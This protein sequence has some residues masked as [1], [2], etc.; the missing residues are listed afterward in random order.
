MDI[1]TTNGLQQKLPWD[2]VTFEYFV[3]SKGANANV[4]LGPLSELFI[5]N[6]GMKV[7]VNKR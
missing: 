1:L 6:Y 2:L 5:S 7:Y 3:H 4:N